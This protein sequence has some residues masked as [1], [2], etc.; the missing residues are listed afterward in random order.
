MSEG[1]LTA[2]GHRV[3]APGVDLYYEVEGTGP[4]C[5]ALPGGPGMHG[6]GFGAALGLGA[7]LTVATLHPRG[8]GESGDPADGDY[9]LPACAR[10]VAALLDHLGRERAIILGHSHGGMIAQRFALDFPGRV[11]KL[12]L[13]DTAANLSE[14]LG[15][16]E[17]A[18]QAYRDR[19]WFAESYRALQREWAGDYQT[20]DDMGALWLA[21]MPLYFR[22]W[23]AQFERLRTER[24]FL[25]IRMAPLQT[26]NEGEALTMDLRPDLARISAPALVMVGRYDFITGPRMAEEIA[27]RI[28]GAQLV[29]FEGSGHMPFFEEPDRWQ[30]VIRAFVERVE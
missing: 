26:F 17:T 29:V 6:R 1:T 13:A 20:A 22:D 11:E 12:I 5:I 15:D 25:P 16:V 4:L 30:A 21:E 28:P 14:F 7:F 10:D 18:V 2:G 24:L 23:G 9:T 3:T 27:G 19:P 8:S